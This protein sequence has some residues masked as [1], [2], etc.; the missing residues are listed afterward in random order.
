MFDEC[1]EDHRLILEEW[2]IKSK[3]SK[4]YVNAI[5]VWTKRDVE[6]FEIAKKNKLNY[7]TIYSKD[8]YKKDNLKEIVNK[9]INY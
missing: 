1:D 4:F 8:Y 9:I 2:K 5:E 6:K 3:I 7:I